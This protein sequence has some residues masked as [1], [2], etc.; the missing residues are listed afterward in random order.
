MI[1]CNFFSTQHKLPT[2]SDLTSVNN[3][4]GNDKRKLHS[5]IKVPF[6]VI[7][8]SRLHKNLVS[9]WLLRSSKIVSSDRSDRSD[10]IETRRNYHEIYKSPWTTLKTEKL[11]RKTNWKSWAHV[12]EKTL[13][14]VIPHPLLFSS[15]QQRYVSKCITYVE[16]DCFC[17]LTLCFLHNCTKISGKSSKLKIFSLI[18]LFHFSGWLEDY[19]GDAIERLSLKLE[20]I[21]GLSTARV[22]CEALQV[23]KI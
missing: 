6:I 18:C 21:T 22:H 11:I 8:V 14:L 19:E 2:L 3:D 13:N 23:I 5:K 7:H 20:A 1:R 10:H 4:Y 17:A 16:S 15:E 9:R 12:L